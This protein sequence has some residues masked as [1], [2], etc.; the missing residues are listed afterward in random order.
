MINKVILIG[1]LGKD[2][3]LRYI[4]TGDTQRAIASFPLATHELVSDKNGGKTEYTEWHN[5]ELWDRNA[6]N[7]AK[8]LKKGRIVYLE[9]KIKSESWIDK[10]ENK[11][12][13][14]KIKAKMFQVLSTLGGS[15]NK[16]NDTSELNNNEVEFDE[17]DFDFDND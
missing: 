16:N 7:A 4:N 2:P 1:R 5:I 9:G 14:T 10:D 8:I 3:E 13:S 17:T 12:Y 6:E 11:R 15:S